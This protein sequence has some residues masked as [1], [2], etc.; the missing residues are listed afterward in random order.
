MN[1]GQ[2]KIWIDR[3]PNGD[4]FVFAREEIDKC[5]EAA[6]HQV[7]EYNCWLRIRKI[8]QLHEGRPPLRHGSV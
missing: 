2:F 4:D 3:G 1:L 6:M 5:A 7:R 8:S